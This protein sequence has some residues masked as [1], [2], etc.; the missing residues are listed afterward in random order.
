MAR[1]EGGNDPK[2]AALAAT[3]CLNPHPEQ[4]RDPGV[5]GQRVLRRS[6]PGAGQVRDGAAG[7]SRRRP[8]HRD[9]RGVRVLPAV[10]LPGSRRARGLRAGG[11]GPRPAR[12]ARRPQ[13]HRR[14]PCLGRAAAGCRPRAAPGAAGR[15]ASSRPSAC[16]CT[17]ARSRKR[18]PAAGSGTPKAA[19][20][21][22]REMRK[23]D[24]PSLPLLPSPG[25]AAAR[26]RHPP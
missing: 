8:G 7:E 9:G 5:P 26:T 19:D 16:A 1:R 22:A 18:W 11:A 12:A 4:V 2:E 24:D 21:P 23:E 3:R 17:P 20:L 25:H 6:R 15:T 14:D 10:V 13:A